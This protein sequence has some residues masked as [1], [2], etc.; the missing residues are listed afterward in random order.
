MLIQEAMRLINCGEAFSYNL[1]YISFLQS[2]SGIDSRPHTPFQPQAEKL[3][4][5]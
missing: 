4:A 3:V 5:L 1:V 2:N